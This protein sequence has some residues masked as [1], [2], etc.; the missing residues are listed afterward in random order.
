MP[1]SAGNRLRWQAVNPSQ[2][3]NCGEP[4][5]PPS[6]IETARDK[7]VIDAYER[8]LVEGQVATSLNGRMIDAANL[9]MARVLI[10]RLRLSQMK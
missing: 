9:R 7:Q 4:H 10:E 2:S 5:V 6:N 1:H 8:A 3:T